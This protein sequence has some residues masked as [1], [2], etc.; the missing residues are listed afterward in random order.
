MLPGRALAVPFEF[1]H[2]DVC[3]GARD[4]KPRGNRSMRCNLDI[5]SNERQ[6]VRRMGASREE[7]IA[8]LLIRLKRFLAALMQSE[9]PGPMFVVVF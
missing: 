7:T 9:R 5:K 8:T 4:G 3:Y 6:Q 2:V 1:V